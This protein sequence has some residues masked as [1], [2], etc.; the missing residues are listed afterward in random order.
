MDKTMTDSHERQGTDGPRLRVSVCMATWNGEQHL[1]PQ[2][3]SILAELGPADELVVVDDASRDGTRAIL[4]EYARHDPRLALFL[5]N[6]NRGSV[7]TFGLALARAGGDVLVLSDQDDIWIPG[8]INAM[9]TALA[10]RADVV[11]TNLVTLGGPDRISGPYPWQSDWKVRVKDSGRTLWNLGS[12]I[13]GAAPYYGCAMALRANARDQ[14]LPFPQ[15][16]DESHDQWIALYGIL[17]RSIV[18]L[19]VRTIARRFHDKNLSS[20]RPRGLAMI[21]HSRL[22][23]C[24]AYVE[25]RRRSRPDRALGR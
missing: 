6:E 11:A 23:L 7:Q 10:A 9:V 2:L 13:L 24:R 22:L 1:R 3:D 19:E 17:N 12:L 25:L 16:L 8:R 15:W 5:E 4:C 21:L 18:H 14:I 20:D